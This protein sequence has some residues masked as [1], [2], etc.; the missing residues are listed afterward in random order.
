M[1]RIVVFNK[2]GSSAVRLCQ[3]CELKVELNLTTAMQIDGEPW[4]Q[5]QSTI[6]IRPFE[7]TKVLQAGGGGC[8]GGGCCGSQASTGAVKTRGASPAVSRQNAEESGLS[9]V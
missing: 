3:A 4:S 7:V 9:E 8:C 1:A 2:L 6:H 5:S